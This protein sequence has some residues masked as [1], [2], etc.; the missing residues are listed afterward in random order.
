MLLKT[1]KQV[2]RLFFIVGGFTVLL[3]GLVLSIPL[4]PGPGFLVVLA[5][6]AMLA[7]EFAWAR[8]LLKRIKDKGVQVRNAVFS[9][10][11]NTPAQ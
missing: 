11:K 6:L 3:V 9:N 8:H 4:V 1:V 10:N 2:K 5:G 7:V